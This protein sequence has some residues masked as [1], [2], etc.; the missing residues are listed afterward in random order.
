MI[1]IVIAMEQCFVGNIFR[2]EHTHL[3]LYSM[4]MEITWIE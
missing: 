3:W 1:L 2:L 4:N